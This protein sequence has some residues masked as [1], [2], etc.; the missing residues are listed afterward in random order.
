M[1]EEHQNTFHQTDRQ[2]NKRTFAFFE[3]LSEPRMV[4]CNSA[5][6]LFIN[7]LQTFY[8]VVLL[9]NDL[10]SSKF[11]TYLFLHCFY[12]ESF[13]TL[14]CGSIFCVDSQFIEIKI[15]TVMQGMIKILFIVIHES[16]RAS[17]I[18]KSNS[19]LQSFFFA[20]FLEMP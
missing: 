19:I 7:A 5:L 12:L 3:L 2:M 18:Q 9:L 6:S 1:N 13:V 15:R 10:Y 20:P 14:K 4:Q 11:K 16:M 8:T 17:Q